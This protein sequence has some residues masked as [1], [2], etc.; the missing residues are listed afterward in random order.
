MPPSRSRPWCR[1]APGDGWRIQRSSLPYRENQ[2]LGFHADESQTGRV[3]TTDVTPSGESLVCHWE[4]TDVQGALSE[5]L[6]E[7]TA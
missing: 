2:L 1:S 7:V 5:V 4:V 3:S 6:Q